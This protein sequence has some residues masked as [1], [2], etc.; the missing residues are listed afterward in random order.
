VFATLFKVDQTNTL[1][2]LD[3]N[4]Q[5]SLGSTGLQF[6]NIAQT[7]HTTFS[8][9]GIGLGN[10]ANYGSAGQFLST[11]GSSLRWFGPLSYI[12]ISGNPDYNLLVTPDQRGGTCIV[13]SNDNVNLVISHTGLA[14]ADAGWFLNI[15]N[16]N[17]TNY[18]ITLIDDP[19]TTTI[20]PNSKVFA[21][22]GSSNG[23]TVVLT[24]DGSHLNAY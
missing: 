1:T 4:G 2:V 16:A 8:N 23:G 15:K 6:Q 18:T 3:V 21:G 14:A 5:A 24:W 19:T 12:D 11:T 9:S 20:S 22:S 10:P 13:R 17:M 7:Q